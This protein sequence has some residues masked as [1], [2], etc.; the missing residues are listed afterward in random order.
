MS[1]GLILSLG[2]YRPVPV[3]IFAKRLGSPLDISASSMYLDEPMHEVYIP[4]TAM[5]PG[6]NLDHVVYT[7]SLTAVETQEQ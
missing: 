3:G 4:L 5:N 7:I 6:C 2:W 1:V